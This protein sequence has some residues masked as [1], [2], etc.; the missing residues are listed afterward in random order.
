LPGIGAAP[1]EMAF[2]DLAGFRAFNNQCGQ[3]AGDAVL[4]EFAQHLKGISGALA[5][6]DGGDEFLVVGAPARPDLAAA[7]DACRATWPDRFRSR[8]GSDVPT[9]VPRFV[10]GSG[11]SRR[12]ATLRERLGR[13]IGMT[14][15]EQLDGDGRGLLRVV[16][17]AI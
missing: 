1:I 13:E 6:R 2:G 17:A 7:V 8:F 10:V 4:R 11:E 14:K 15:N 16:S 5:I 12:I 3:D 9:V